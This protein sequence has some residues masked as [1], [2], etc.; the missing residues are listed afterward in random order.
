MHFLILRQNG[1]SMIISG[2]FA[3]IAAAV[4]GAMMSSSMKPVAKSRSAGAYIASGG[5]LKLRRHGDRYVRTSE[6]RNRVQG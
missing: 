2:V 1:D 4:T 3:L 5:S 6:T